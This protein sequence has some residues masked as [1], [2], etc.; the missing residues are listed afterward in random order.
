[1]SDKT[2]EGDGSDESEEKE[3]DPESSPML[4]IDWRASKIRRVHPDAAPASALA[5]ARKAHQELLS[6]LAAHRTSR[7]ACGIIIKTNS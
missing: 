3:P 4:W 2:D 5:A 6:Q 1:M 7:P